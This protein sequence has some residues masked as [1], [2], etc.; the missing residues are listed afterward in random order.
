MVASASQQP[1]GTL[2]PGT[3]GPTVSGGK[4]RN[5][6]PDWVRVGVLAVTV[7][8]VFALLMG[9][10]YAALLFLELRQVEQNSVDIVAGPDGGFAPATEGGGALEV[11]EIDPVLDRTTILLVGSDSR[12]GLSEDQLAAIGTDPTGTD[13]T[14]T[15]ILLQLDPATDTA[16][17]LSFPRDLVVERCDGS[18]GRING[19]Y[20]IGEDQA[21]GLGPK[22]LVD[23]ITA[24]TRI[25]IDHYARVNFA[26]F[27][28]A[29]DALGGVEFYVEE[30]IDDPFSGLD[31]PAGCV[32]FDGVGAIQF[33]R[34][35]RI[36]NDFGRIA[37][38]QRF[39]REMIN[40]ATSLGTLANPVRVASLIG[41][42]SEVIE[43]DSN[44][45]VSQMADLVT[46]VQTITSGGI[47]GRTVPAIEG[48]L[49]EAD[50]VYAIEEEAE[51][52]YQAFRAGDL[53]PDDVG[54]DDVPQALGPTNVVAVEV[55]NGAGT[56]G[57]ATQTAVA[58]EA[59]GFTVSA[60]G[61]A[62]NYGFDSSLVLYPPDR[63]D[64]AEILAEALGG[65]AVDAGDDEAEGLVL[66]L[67][68]DFEPD[69]LDAPVPD[70]EASEGGASEGEA[71]EGGAS[72]GG[73]SEGG[74]SE[75]APAEESSEDA[76][77]GAALSNV[78]C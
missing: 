48:R 41:S 30:A 31:I 25:E 19:A 51:A 57:L 14:D 35:R 61:E 64:H 73:A 27:V 28:S 54:I 65:I 45:G 59:L 62:A 36:D 33:V 50:V 77:V 44:F 58:L 53:L 43:T 29:V 22:C 11:P 78:Q 1:G 5:G 16:A 32:E 55:L 13:L 37:R 75:G 7:V 47:D 38:Q 8:T 56:E 46:S 76:F 9:S 71:S 2:F 24:L 20:A 23:S 15:V 60:T 74:A 68:S 21:Q 69:A 52:L 10:A 39:A 12:D 18:R 66:I 42:I 3:F 49:G 17:M 4:P 67:G 70:G 34:A 26:G 40:K 72:E 6:G 63:Q